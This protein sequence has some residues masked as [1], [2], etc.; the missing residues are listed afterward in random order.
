MKRK[1][2]FWKYEVSER[3]VRFQHRHWWPTTINDLKRERA[4]WIRWCHD[5]EGKLAK[6]KDT[7]NM[8][9]MAWVILANAT[10]WDRS[11]RSEWITAAQKW[12]DDYFRFLK[13]QE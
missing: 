6:Q 1:L 10:D 13:E 8:L 3:I 5:A 2:A 7:G 12:R 11:E 9:E 4:D